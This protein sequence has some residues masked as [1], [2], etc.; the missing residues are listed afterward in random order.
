MNP[1]F[2]KFYLLVDPWLENWIIKF[3]ITIT[4]LI[5]V[6]ALRMIIAYYASSQS[7]FAFTFL[8]VIRYRFT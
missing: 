3:Q 7:N 2:E 5:C 1:D 8:K 6:I 4:N